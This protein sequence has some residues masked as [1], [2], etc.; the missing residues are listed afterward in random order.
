ME[1][2][3]EGPV[4]GSAQVDWEALAR[5]LAGESPAEEAD[6]VRAWLARD[7]SRHDVL[8]ALDTTLDRA[9]AP[10]AGLDVEAALR[11]VHARM[12][13]PETPVIPFRAPARRA[14]PAPRRMPAPWLRAAAA[15]V[16]LLGVG[17]FT[18]RMMTGPG[19]AR[20]P[21][22][23]ATGVGQRD[24]VRL[25]DGTMVIL[26][27]DSRLTLA[28]DYGREARQVELRGEAMFD[29]PHDEARP[30]TVRAGG[31][32]VRDLGTTFS[33]QADSAAGVR[34]VVTQ[35]AVALGTG[36]AREDE[37]V[38]LRQGDRGTLAAGRI[39]AERAVATADDVAWTQGRLVFRDA[40]FG[41]VAAE[42][43]R[44][45]GL[46]LRA[47]DA[48]VA[49]RRLTASFQ[50]EPPGDVLRVVGLALGAEVTM[51][52]DTAV[53]RAASPGAPR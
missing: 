16:L 11:G 4:T 9:S 14:A 7:R 28:R 46:H 37:A 12:D 33:V 15:I 52:G 30:F 24:T 18:W 53:F 22:S 10:P 23:F 3:D 36:E 39:Q 35:G 48:T 17:W 13:A 25:G 5:F 50:G 49:T 38:V 21:V 40:P 34:V 6:A 44:W 2:G 47:G 19:S 41:Q 20:P 51:R 32:W 43:R 27:P 26:G 8:S 31:A 29:V 42:L 1:N 45:Y